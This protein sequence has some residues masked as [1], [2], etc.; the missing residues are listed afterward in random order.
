MLIVALYRLAARVLPF[1]P[2]GLGYWLCDRAGELLFALLPGPRAGVMSNQRHAL[3]LEALPV[4]V[5]A[6]SRQVFRNLIRSYFD[7]FR[8]SRMCPEELQRLVTVDGIEHVE[9][10]LAGGKGL[11]LVSAHFGAP[12]VVAQILVAW[13]YRITVV[14]EHIQPEE[15]FQLMTSLRGSQGI[16]F[17]PIDGALRPI[18]RALRQNG[19]VGLVA[20]RDTSASG[21]RL[22]F[23]GDETR[24]ADGAAKLA[25]RT[26]APIL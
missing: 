8:L 4:E 24:V 22:P 15:V 10:A 6:S 2:R 21:I 20:D 3:G 1:V 26:G 25:L 19:L 23:L 14:A 18:I 13:N 5:E 12:E 11:I 9:E 16:E 17:I 7:Q